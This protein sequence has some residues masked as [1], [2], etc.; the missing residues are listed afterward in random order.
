MKLSLEII[1]SNN[2]VLLKVA[3]TGI[4]IAKEDFNIIFDEFRQASEGMS[5]NFEGSGLGLNI[6]KK[7]V[8][9]MGGTITVESELGK[10][11]EFTVKLPI[12]R[13]A[14]K[15]TTE[16]VK[17]IEKNETIQLNYV[18]ALLLVDDDINVK[19]ILTNY[20]SGNFKLAH[21]FNG[22][23][24]VN[25]VKNKKFDAILMDINLKGGMD[26]IKTT[27]EIRKIKGYENI[28]IIAC[29]A[30]AM[31]GDRDEFLSS[32]CSH[33]IAKPFSKNEIISFFKEVFS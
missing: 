33:Y 5:R 22:Q 2:F 10:G 17:E 30:F 18:P 21:V 8:E 32:G 16:T 3:D 4:G 15:E 24:A 23:D 25:V 14:V 9:K 31:A 1:D 6:T 13:S 29:T 27:K 12:V 28:P 26:G 7:F 11:T 19:S 20:L